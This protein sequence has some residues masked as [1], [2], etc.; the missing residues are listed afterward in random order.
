VVKVTGSSNRRVSLAALLCTNLRELMERM[1][2]RSTRA[3]M[4][5]LHSTSERQRALA[6]TL[7]ALVATKLKSGRADS[8]AS[9]T[10]V[11]R[12]GADGA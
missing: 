9:G 1:G 3:A 10:E 12:H 8:K 4:I 7:G 6:D 2:H 11:A 5:Y